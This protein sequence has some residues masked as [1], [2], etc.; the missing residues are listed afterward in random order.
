MVIKNIILYI[1]GTKNFQNIF[2]FIVRKGTSHSRRKKNAQKLASENF[3]RQGTSARKKRIPQKT[4][5]ESQ[6]K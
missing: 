2:L 4:A 3:P 1:F 6:I 5:K